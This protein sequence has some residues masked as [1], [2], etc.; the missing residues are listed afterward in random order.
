MNKKSVALLIGIVMIIFALEWFIPEY[1]WGA[2]SEVTV[3][4]ESSEEELSEQEELVLDTLIFNAVKV[5][6]LS[7]DE[8]V[9]HDT[10]TELLNTEQVE[11]LL[12]GLSSQYELEGNVNFYELADGEYMLSDVEIVAI[13]EE[14]IQIYLTYDKCAKAYIWPDE[15]VI[16]SINDVEVISGCYEEEDGEIVYFSEFMLKT[17]AYHIE[18]KET[19]E[20]VA[21]ETLYT[22]IEKVIKGSA[23]EL[24]SIVAEFTVE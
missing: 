10:V 24:G 11:L 6:E 5:K 13:T 2:D 23:A 14:S 3:I 20:N 1:I 12:A 19:A 17:T 7:E 9:N 4:D 21:E 16:S 22:I 15:Y 18:I 8:V